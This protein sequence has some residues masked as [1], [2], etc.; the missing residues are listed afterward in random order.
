MNIE[1][2][3]LRAVA[4]DAEAYT[5]LYSIYNADEG[6]DKFN[7]FIKFLQYATEQ[8][9][10]EAPRVL[11]DL[12]YA[13]W[14]QGSTYEMMRLLIIAVER[15]NKSAKE[16]IAYIRTKELN[17]FLESVYFDRKEKEL[18]RGLDKLIGFIIK[19]IKL[20]IADCNSQELFYPYEYVFD[21]GSYNFAVDLQPYVGDKYYCVNDSN[22]KSFL[23]CR[24]LCECVKH[25]DIG[26]NDSL[27]LICGAA[28]SVCHTQENWAHLEILSAYL[29]LGGLYVQAE[30]LY[31]ASEIYGYIASTIYTLGLLLSDK[32]VV[33]CTY[34]NSLLFQI[35]CYQKLSPAYDEMKKK[36]TT[37]LFD[38]LV[39]QKD[40]EIS[41]GWLKMEREKVIALSEMISINDAVLEILANI[42]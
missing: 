24:T 10:A 38:M 15:G 42:L 1:E 39:M 21:F 35:D 36:V 7:E 31:E 16:N 18:N 13:G 28:S 14:G 33:L 4:G 6:D 25:K 22:F 5:L 27:S 26:F 30:K 8:G 19:D 12:Y 23:F 40:N 2:L 17:L 9:D 37:Q 20:F 32:D 11:A 29:Q 3:K 34:Y 41:S